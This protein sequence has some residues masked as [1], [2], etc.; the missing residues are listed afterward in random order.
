[1]GTGKPAEGHSVKTLAGETGITN[2]IQM[3]HPVR[4]KGIGSRPGSCIAGIG[5]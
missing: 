4:L 2:A 3:L 1:M 5:P